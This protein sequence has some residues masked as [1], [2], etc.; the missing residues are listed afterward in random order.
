MNALACDG[1][2]RRCNNDG[3]TA[4][5]VVRGKYRLL[6]LLCLRRRMR[7]MRARRERMVD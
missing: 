1:L 5:V 4:R 3:P 2:G 6:C 7:Q